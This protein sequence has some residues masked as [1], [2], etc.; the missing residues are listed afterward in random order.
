MKY[1]NCNYDNITPE[2]EKQLLILVGNDPKMGYKEIQKHFNLSYY[3]IAK[4]KHKH[5]LN[6]RVSRHV[7]KQSLLA[8][9][10]R[11]QC[12]ICKNILPITEKFNAKR[13][14]CIDCQRESARNHYYKI[15][16]SLEALLIHRLKK[17]QKRIKGKLKILCSL[18][19]EDL[20][21]KYKL[22]KGLCFYTK[23]PLKL[24][25][26]ENF[27]LS[28]DRLDPAQ[29]YIKENVVLCGSIINYMKQDL[30]FEKFLEY[31]RL[32]DYR[33]TD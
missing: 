7:T 18:T 15:Y 12:A 19:L 33:F 2:I 25:A 3:T 9:N 16:N 28:L 6:S 24:C 23:E 21:E 1:K 4:F 11:R 17:A 5:H 20:H 22:Q 10:G 13:R 8:E 32:V 14:T 30:S 29:G 27:T 26:N 31:C